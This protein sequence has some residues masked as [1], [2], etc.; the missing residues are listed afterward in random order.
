MFKDAIYAAIGS[1]D[2]PPTVVLVDSES[3]NDVDSTA[4]AMIQ[5]LT[6]ELEG[7][8]VELWFARVKAHVLELVRR[9]GAI[10][11][12][13]PDTTHSSLRSAVEAFQ[14]QSG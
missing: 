14:R 12:M 13:H 4:M 1:T 3:I 9:F 5:E 7:D 2:P 8:G 6:Q 10:E 11:T